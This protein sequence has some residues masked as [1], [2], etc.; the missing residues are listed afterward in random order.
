MKRT[1]MDI[2]EK[3]FVYPAVNGEIAQTTHIVVMKIK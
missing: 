2:K 1:R 3:L